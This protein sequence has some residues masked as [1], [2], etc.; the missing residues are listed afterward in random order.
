[1]F[2]PFSFIAAISAE[3]ALAPSVRAIRGRNQV[4]PRAPSGL[5]AGLF[6]ELRH[7][8]GAAPRISHGEKRIPA[9]DPSA[10]RLR[11]TLPLTCKKRDRSCDLSLFDCFFSTRRPS[12]SCAWRACRSKRTR[13]TPCP[14]PEACSGRKRRPFPSFPA[15]SPARRTTWSWQSRPRS[16]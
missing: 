10:F 5:P 1:M 11:M 8:E 4:P 9:G 12:R 6:A 3:M 15:R 16:P 2:L 14:E 7:S 13:R